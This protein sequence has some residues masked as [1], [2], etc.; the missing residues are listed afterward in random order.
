M[1]TVR[2]EFYSQVQ[3]FCESKKRIRVS[4]KEGQVKNVGW[5]F[6][7]IVLQVVVKTNSSSSKKGEKKTAAWE[8]SKNK[9]RRVSPRNNS[10]TYCKFYSIAD[11]LPNHYTRL[12]KTGTRVIENAV[13]KKK[14]HECEERLLHSTCVVYILFYFYR[15]GFLNHHFKLCN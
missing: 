2:V 9:S 7:F 4:V 10:H 6:Q 15:Y 14:N 1:D 12:R 3:R 13:V 5:T 11:L 8:I